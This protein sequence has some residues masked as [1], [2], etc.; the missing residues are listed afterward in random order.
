MTAYSWFLLAAALI[1]GPFFGGIVAGFDR[2]ISARM[3]G[4]VGPPIFQPFYDAVKLW[5]KR[6]KY[7]SKFQTIAI[8]LFLVSNALGLGLLAMQLDLVAMLFV[9]GLGS[10]SFILAAYSIKSPYGMLGAQREVMQLLIYEPLLIFLVVG[11]YLETGSFIV[12]KIFEL[13]YPL[14]FRMPLFFV[15]MVIVMLVKLRKS[16]FDIAASAHHA[17]QEV[18]QGP[19]SEMAGRTLAMVEV[20]HWYELV[21]LLALVS[22]LWGTNPIGAILLSMAA[23]FCTTVIDNLTARMSWN[24]MLGTGWMLGLVLAIV[25]LVAIYA[26]RSGV[27]SWG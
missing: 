18:V 4:R 19:F 14:L 2:N 13:P 11:F 5:N 12:A 16:P 3:Q 1:G 9:L 27:L 8:W 24:W 22:L 15:T 23:L 6:D 7:G 26:A 25:N 20:G 10:V 17:H 21:V